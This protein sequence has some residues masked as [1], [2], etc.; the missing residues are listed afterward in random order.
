MLHNGIFIFL[1]VVYVISLQGTIE[2]WNTI[3]LKLRPIV[4]NIDRIV[5]DIILEENAL[6]LGWSLYVLMEWKYDFVD[7]VLKQNGI[8]DSLHFFIVHSLLQSIQCGLF[9]FIGSHHIA[10]PL[11]ECF[12]HFQELAL[13]VVQWI[14]IAFEEVRAHC[15]YFSYLLFGSLQHFLHFGVQTF[16]VIVELKLEVVQV[17][18]YLLGYIILSIIDL[19]IQVMLCCFY[20]VVHSVFE[21]E[22]FL[23]EVFDLLLQFNLHWVHSR[24]L[25]VAQGTYPIQYFLKFAIH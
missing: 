22:Q 19:V 5:I 12:M 13:Q 20:I 8:I 16:H 24:F 15:L 1:L 3:Y 11:L 23:V 18:L 4:L 10:V 6:I 7:N 17:Q 14:L 9:Q 21:I 25:F 2:F